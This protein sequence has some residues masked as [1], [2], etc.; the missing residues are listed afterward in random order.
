MAVGILLTCG[1]HLHDLIKK[2]G[3]HIQLVELLCIYV[4][5]YRVLE[6]LRQCGTFFLSFF[7]HFIVEQT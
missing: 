7:L 6:L 2:G 4:V 1:E 3:G 5:G